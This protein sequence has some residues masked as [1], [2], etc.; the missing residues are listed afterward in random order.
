MNMTLERTTG[1]VRSWVGG[2]L[3]AKLPE[4]LR[5]PGG[6]QLGLHGRWLDP[7]DLARAIGERPPRD[8]VVFFVHGL[9]RNE[10]CFHARSFDMA[11]AFESDFDLWAVD[12]RYDTGRHVSDNGHDLAAALEALFGALGETCGGWHIVAHSMGGLVVRSALHQAEAAG[13]GFVRAIDKVFLL[14]TPNHGARLEQATQAASLSLDLAVPV[15]EGTARRVRG[16]LT[17]IRIGNV[18]PLAPVAAVTDLS[19][20]VLPTFFVRLASRV[21]ELRSD[22]IRDLRFGT[23]LREEW[24][25]R[26]AW[27]GLA[28]SRR[29][30][31]P[32]SG[33]RIY[34]VAGSL[35]RKPDAAIPH[36]TTDGLVTAASA[37]CAVGDEL[38]LV[39][40]GRFRVLAGVGHISLP[41][42]RRVYR[43][44]SEWF[45]EDGNAAGATPATSG[46]PGPPSGRR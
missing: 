35:S 30:V 3:G 20:D 19:V 10:N 12:V 42:S 37:A 18:A 24:E 25:Q 14:G 5:W 15:L 16:A 13:M 17:S 29:P 46:A 2:L 40:S 11:A 8:G 21:L 38:G 33:V 41:R 27:G 34:A 28:S 43:T 4:Q 36:S 9:M 26:P 1:Q 7:A 44:I 22:G 39:A 23:M 45:R 6:V 32:P 31:P